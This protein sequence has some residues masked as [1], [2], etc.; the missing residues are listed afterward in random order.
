MHP[1]MIRRVVRPPGVGA[2]APGAGAGA[3]GAGAGA[4]C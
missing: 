4:A 1:S 3:P 2:G